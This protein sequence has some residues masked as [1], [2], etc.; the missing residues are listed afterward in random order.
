MNQRSTVACRAAH[1]VAEGPQ[2]AAFTVRLQPLGI[3]KQHAPRRAWRQRIQPRFVLAGRLPLQ[4]RRV[5][6]GASVDL[7]L[8]LLLRGLAL[9]DVAV[10]VATVA[11]DG[12]ARQQRTLGQADAE[13]AF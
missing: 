5:L 13:D 3:G 9:F 12:K 8:V 2:R 4:Q 1:R 11:I 6:G 10:D 7:S